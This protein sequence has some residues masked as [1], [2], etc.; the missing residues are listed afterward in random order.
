MQPRF[1]SARNGQNPGS[2][3]PGSAP[4]S[5]ISRLGA[6]GLCRVFPQGQVVGARGRTVLPPLRPGLRAALSSPLWNSP[7]SGHGWLSFPVGSGPVL[8]ARLL[9]APPAS[10][11]GRKNSH[12]RGHG[13]GGPWDSPCLSQGCAPRLFTGSRTGTTLR[14]GASGPPPGDRDA[15]LRAMAGDALRLP[16]LAPNLAPETGGKQ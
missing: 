8:G 13:H 10:A 3:S 5:L 14:G 9:L 6:L 15:G 2:T 1:A 4:T 16:S 11:W 7:G 12:E